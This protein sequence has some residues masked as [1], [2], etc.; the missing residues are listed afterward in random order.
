MKQQALMDLPAGKLLDKFGSGG[1]KPG[2]GSAAA[3]MG[4]LSGKLIITVASLSLTKPKYQQDWAKI[5]YIKNEI[6]SKIEPELKRLFEYDSEVFDEVITLR[7]MRNKASSPKEIKKLGGQ[8]LKKLREAAEIPHNICEESLKL[9]DH[10]IAVFDMGFQSAR[11]DT[12]AAVS[13]AVAGAMA[14]IFVINL[15]LRSFRSS[16]WANGMRKRCDA[17]HKKLEVKQEEAFGR[18]MTLK[19]ENVESMGFGFE[20][21]KK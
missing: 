1:H 10:G 19:E 20:E 2:S 14:S 16:E 21:P 17:L 13:A 4:I 15:N 18:V 7:N 5:E 8:A 3:L 11:G 12:G 6:E 9:I